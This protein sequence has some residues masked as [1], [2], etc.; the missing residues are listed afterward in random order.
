M[1]DL[2]DKIAWMWNVLYEYLVNIKHEFHFLVNL[3]ARWY[4]WYDRDDF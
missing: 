1:L 3:Y 2:E 4:H